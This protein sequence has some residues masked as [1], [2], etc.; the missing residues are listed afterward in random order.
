MHKVYTTLFLACIWMS[1]GTSHII[2]NHTKYQLS[3]C[4][5][6]ALQFYTKYPITTDYTSTTLA[7]TNTSPLKPT[8][9]R[10]RNEFGSNSSIS[11]EHISFDILRDDKPK[12]ACRHTC[13]SLTRI[14]QQTYINISRHHYHYHRQHYHHISCHC[15]ALLYSY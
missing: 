4:L 14:S 8:A 15:G 12:P 3:L 7:R 9:P 2:I 6:H 1:F 10:L 11:G 13:Y 5:N